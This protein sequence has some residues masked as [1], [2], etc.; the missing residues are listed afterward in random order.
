MKKKK[1][2][3]EKLVLIENLYT[4]LDKTDARAV[5]TN[6][7]H[8]NQQENFL[9]TERFLTLYQLVQKNI[10]FF[11]WKTSSFISFPDDAVDRRKLEIKQNTGSVRPHLI[12][13]PVT[14]EKFGIFCLL[15]TRGSNQTRVIKKSLLQRMQRILQKI[16]KECSG[17]RKHIVVF[18]HFHTFVYIANQP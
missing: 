1:K 9:G 15:P 10:V 6:P 16:T 17:A 8:E 14:R 3:A 7:N 11:G 2:I 4:G 12:R 13:L 18:C 5:M